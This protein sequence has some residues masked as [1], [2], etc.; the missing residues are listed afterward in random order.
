MSRVGQKPVE[1][2]QGVKVQVSAAT[3]LAEGPKGKRNLELHP[4]VSVVHK[5]GKIFCTRSDD[6]RSTRALHGLYRAL[7]Q[8]LVTGVAKGFEKRLEIVG[9][10]YG[11]AVEGKSLKLTV[12]FSQPV[13][14]A[15]PDGLTVTTPD[16]NHVVVSGPDKQL[17]GQFA[18]DVRKVR[19]PEPY[20][21]FGIKYEG[22]YVRRKAGK[23]FGGTA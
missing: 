3:I 16:A 17:V 9:I 11:A 18:A 14:L 6:E 20:K 21:G 22:E 10:G 4:R 1:I 7:I 23:A 15:I 19:K 5:D 2:P 13:K 12:G 8:N